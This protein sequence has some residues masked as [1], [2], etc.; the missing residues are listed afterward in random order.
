MYTVL[1]FLNLLAISVLAVWLYLVN[2]WR[3]TEIEKIAKDVRFL[4]LEHGKDASDATVSFGGLI[5]EMAADI[6]FIKDKVFSKKERSYLYYLGELDKKAPIEDKIEDI[7]KNHLRL[8][9]YLKL[10]TKT[11]TSETKVV[12]IKK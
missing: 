1:L 10:T 5:T 9:D 11:T 12:K 3:I 7:H 8:M 4:M 2:K 6:N